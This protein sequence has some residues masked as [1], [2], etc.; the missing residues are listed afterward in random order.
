[1]RKEKREKLKEGIEKREKSIETLAQELGIDLEVARE[2]LRKAEQKQ[3]KAE[4]AGRGK[5]PVAEK[6]EESPEPQFQLKPEPEPKPVP[7]PEL[8]SAPIPTPRP[9]PKPTPT[10]VQQSTQP[11]VSR[12]ERK[13]AVQKNSAYLRMRIMQGKYERKKQGEDKQKK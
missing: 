9:I 2:A 5:R 13:Q 12:E 7:K 6:K 3:K 11:T 4:R 8:V 1:M 10:P